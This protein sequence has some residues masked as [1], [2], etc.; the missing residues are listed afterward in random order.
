MANSLRGDA[1]DPLIGFDNNVAFRQQNIPDVYPQEA[2][3]DNS[4]KW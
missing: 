3:R 4:A 2:T 1:E